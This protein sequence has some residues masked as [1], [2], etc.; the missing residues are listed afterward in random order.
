VNVLHLFNHYLPQTENWAYHLVRNIP[1]ARTFIAAKRYLPGEFLHQDFTFYEHPFGELDKLNES[2][3]KE[4]NIGLSK[5]LLYKGRKLLFGDMRRFLVPFIKDHQVQIL[6]AHFADIGWYYHRLAAKTKL[7]LVVSFYG[8]DYEML[9][10]TKPVYVM[11]LQKLFQNA[12]ALV[13]EGPHGAETLV[14]K[15]CPVKK[16]HVVPLGVQ[17]E[18]IPFFQRDKKAQ[19]LKLLQV[20]SFTEKKGHI[21]TLKAVANSRKQ[22]PG[23]KLTFVGGSN[24]PGYRSFIQK[25]VARHGLSGC[26]NFIDQIN[27]SSLHSFMKD[28]DVFIHP[29]CHA[30]N[31]DCEGGAPIVLLDAQATGMPVISTI[32]CDIPSEVLQGKTGR[33]ALEKDHEAIAGFIREFYQMNAEAYQLIA[34]AARQHVAENYDIPKNATQLGKLYKK[35][36]RK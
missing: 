12:D 30:E 24:Q 19:E 31:G 23:L 15:G 3:R 26:I 1:E 36:I 6:H 7:P 35:L 27:F 34:K 8:W 11:R 28:F 29:S 32:H 21:A 4:G 33:L 13:C 9:S 18:K 2:W 17:V 14:Q 16:V 10:R 20:A 5:R 25:E 22:C